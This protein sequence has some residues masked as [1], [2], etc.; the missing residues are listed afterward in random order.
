[1]KDLVL[2]IVGSTGWLA[3]VFS[4]TAMLAATGMWAW[5]PEQFATPSWI[6]ALSICAGLVGGVVVKRTIDNSKLAKPGVGDGGN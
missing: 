1:M 5:R 2:G 6:Q 4:I 3:T